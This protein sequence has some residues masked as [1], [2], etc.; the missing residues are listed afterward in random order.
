MS[1]YFD[2]KSNKELVDMAIIRGRCLRVLREVES[3]KQD[4]AKLLQESNPS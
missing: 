3:I 2:E 4:A 1:E